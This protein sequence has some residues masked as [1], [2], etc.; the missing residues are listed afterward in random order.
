M[1]II[2]ELNVAERQPEDVVI[3]SRLITWKPEAVKLGTRM[4]IAI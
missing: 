4:R 2:G 1:T 3:V